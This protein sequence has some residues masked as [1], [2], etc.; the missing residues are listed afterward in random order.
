MWDMKYSE[1]YLISNKIMVK[2]LLIGWCWINFM[3]VVIEN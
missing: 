3:I 2:V 1:C